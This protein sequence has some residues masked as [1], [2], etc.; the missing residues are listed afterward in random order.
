VL[1]CKTRSDELVL[2]CLDE[3]FR[4]EDFADED[5]AD[6]RFDG[7]FG[8]DSVIAVAFFARFAALTVAEH[9][10]FRLIAFPAS[11]SMTRD[12]KAAKTSEQGIHTH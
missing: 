3:G 1:V 5:L 2:A 11:N 7:V 9:A 4:D 10:G 8:G 12:G 6:E